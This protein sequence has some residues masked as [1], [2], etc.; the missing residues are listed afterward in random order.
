M[1][2]IKQHVR[3]G[4]LRPL[5]LWFANRYR[6]LLRLFTYP[7]TASVGRV[8]YDA[9]WDEKFAQ[10]MGGMSEWRL[11]RARVF[12]SLVEEGQ[13]VLDL[14]V[15]DGA[16]LKFIIDETGATGYGLDISPKAVEFCR[17]NGLDVDLADV[18]AP[19]DTFV[20]RPYDYIILSEIIEHIP[21]PERMLT[22][23][24]PHV[25]NAIVVSVPNTGF[26]QHRLRLLFGRFP[27]QWVVTPGEHLRFWTHADFLW[28]ADQLGF[29]VKQAIPYEGVPGMKSVWPGVFAAAFVYVLEP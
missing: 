21:D 7:E 4:A 28:W 24:R 10:G 26:Y 2:S 20:T 27:L 29:R 16:L 5:Y 14:G 25:R 11:K 9:Y 12:A 6:R 19:I 18:N 15:G 1:Q 3:E 13:T 22:E 17:Q 8:D 23:L